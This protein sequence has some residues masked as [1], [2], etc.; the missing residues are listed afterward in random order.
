MARKSWQNVRTWILL[1]LKSPCFYTLPFPW[2]F[3]S[4]LGSVSYMH[5]LQLTLS[6]IKHI[7]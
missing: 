6:V 5:S 3:N 2:L 7:A 4:S 1:R